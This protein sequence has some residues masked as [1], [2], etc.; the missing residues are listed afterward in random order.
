MSYDPLVEGLLMTR[1]Q[2]PLGHLDLDLINT[3][4]AN[5][6]QP[7]GRPKPPLVR[8]A[9]GNVRGRVLIGLCST[10]HDHERRQK[11]FTRTTPFFHGRSFF[12]G[13]RRH[14][15]SDDGDW[16]QVLISR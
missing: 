14:C 2:W 8:K 7:A 5:E 11:C 12:L 1:D 6:I 10:R 16:P 9:G 4:N 13:A 3:L 15:V